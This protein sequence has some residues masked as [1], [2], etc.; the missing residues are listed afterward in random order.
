MHEVSMIKKIVELTLQQIEEHH[1]EF[2]S[3]ICV[4]MTVSD[5]LNESSVQSL[6]TSLA[7]H[8]PAEHAQLA[9]HWNPA[10]YQCA[11]CGMQSSVWEYVPYT[12]CLVCGK[13]ALPRTQAHEWSFDSIVLAGGAE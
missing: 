12:D 9:I 8:T 6:F 3:V 4:S 13:M 5:H 1:A 7:A 2:A 11:T 10:V